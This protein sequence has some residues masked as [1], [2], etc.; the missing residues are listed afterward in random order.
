MG[1]R[2][3]PANEEWTP[4]APYKKGLS[5]IFM[6]RTESGL[7]KNLKVFETTGIEI[8]RS[9]ANKKL[10]LMDEIGGVEL[11]VPEF[12]KVLLDS[13]AGSVPCIGVIKSQKNLKTMAARVPVRLESS[14]RLM[15]LEEKIRKR[16]K[17]Q[18][19][20]FER[21]NENNIRESILDFLKENMK[22]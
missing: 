2:M 21:N 9:S 22:K 20:I 14:S 15:E 16:G 8:L 11:F 5:N 3:V 12:M 13:M 17:G 10:C 1:F 6:E 7:Q 4:K 19:L 18:V